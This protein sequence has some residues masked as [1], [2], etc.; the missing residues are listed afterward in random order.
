M[1]ILGSL[2]GW[3]E[4]LRYDYDIGH[5]DTVLDIGSYK[6][7][8]SQRFREKGCHVIE[9]D[10]NTKCAWIYDGYINIGGRD[11]KA[12]YLIKGRNYPCV[13]I[14]KF[15]ETEIALC[16]INIEGGEYEL[17][18]HILESG[19]QSNVH[20]FQIQFHKVGEFEKRYKDIARNLSQTHKLSWRHPFVWENWKLNL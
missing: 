19:L 3:N 2:K 1:S 14:I 5:G 18:D 16:K 9:F 20:N 15:I 6:G 17:M 8:F 10:T 7:E 12:S 4:D 11:N 13:D